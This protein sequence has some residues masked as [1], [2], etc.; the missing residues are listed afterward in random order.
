MDLM[1]KELSKTAIITDSGIINVFFMI[2]QEAILLDLYDEVFVTP[3]I[4]DDFAKSLD[5]ESFK[6]FCKKIKKCKFNVSKLNLDSLKQQYPIM[7]DDEAFAMVYGMSNQVDVILD[8]P[9]KA[10]ILESRGVNVLRPSD[11]MQQLADG[12]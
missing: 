6:I 12:R 4:Y 8:D 3:N 9:R 10:Y 11:I 1:T 5:M 7:N 2:G